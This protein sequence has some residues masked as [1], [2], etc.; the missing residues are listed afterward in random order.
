LINFNVVK[1]TDGVRRIVNPD[2]I[3]EGRPSAGG[4][5]RESAPTNDE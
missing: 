1:L 3:A 4:R 2:V 5:V